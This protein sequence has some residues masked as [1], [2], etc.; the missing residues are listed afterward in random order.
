MNSS[1]SDNAYKQISKQLNELVLA[2]RLLVISN[3]L[4]D[5]YQPAR[6]SD[7]IYNKLDIPELNVLE[8]F[9]TLKDLYAFKEDS[10]VFK[11]LNSAH[12]L[13]DLS[14]QLRKLNSGVVDTK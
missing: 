7:I 6:K 10:F 8:D 1:I 5:S 2:D 12:D 4:F 9:I 11:T 14:I 13:L 3:L